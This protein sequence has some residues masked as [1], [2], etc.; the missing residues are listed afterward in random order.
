MNINILLSALK[1][2]ENK[3]VFTSPA[4]N[5]IGSMRMAGN[6]GWGTYQFP[7]NNVKSWV[8]GGFTRYSLPLRKD[9]ASKFQ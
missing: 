1:K 3:M 5:T 4:K 6:G 7:M 8:V 2:I 9:C